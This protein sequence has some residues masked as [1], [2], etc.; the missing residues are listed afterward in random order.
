LLPPL[1][2][3]ARLLIYRQIATCGK[4]SSKSN[5]LVRRRCLASAT[6]LRPRSE[7]RGGKMRAILVLLASFAAAVPVLAK[8]TGLETDL[9][10]LDLENY[11][12]LVSEDDKLYAIQ[13]RVMPLDKRFEVII[14]GGQNL[15]GDGFLTTRQVS[16]E[17][18]FH[19]NK[20]WSVGAAY[21]HVSNS[22]SPSAEGLIANQRLTPNVDRTNSRTE[23]RVQ[24]NLFYGKIR[25]LQDAITYFDQY[26]ALGI[27]SNQLNSGQSAGPLLDAG[28]AFWL[29]SWGSVHWGL[30]DY[31][32]EE[33]TS[34]GPG[35]NHNLYVYLG[36]GF[37][38]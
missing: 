34:F 30:K 38:P 31:Y 9:K 21:G 12:I 18:R 26:W 19:F 3:S 11:N 8:T 24:Y 2:L 7:F 4:K 32:Y 15:T 1:E 22:W 33:R 37:L 35:Y 16:F 36:L 27:A 23:A 6:V 29:P 25:W 5:L 28:F 13:P 17:G 20:L 14:G 10:T